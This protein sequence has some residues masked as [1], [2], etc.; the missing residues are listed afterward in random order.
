M[1]AVVAREF[2]NELPGVV[3]RT[4]VSAAIKA[5]ATKVAGDKG[6]DVGQLV[7]MLYQAGSTAAD[8]RTWTALPKEFHVCR[9]DTPSERIISISTG[10]GA[11][12]DVTV[13]DA[14][15]SVVYVKD[16]GPNTLLKVNQFPLK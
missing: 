9:F 3:A 1:D 8:L 5:A 6:G 7:G 15:I 13:D 14:Q 2:K 12:A 16:F 10:G 4:I 11:K